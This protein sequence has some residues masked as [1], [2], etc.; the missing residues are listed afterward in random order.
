MSVPDPGIDWDDVVDVIC[1]GAAPGV[2]AY[3]ICCAAADLDVLVI[4]PPE[5]PEAGVADLIAAMTEDLDLPPVESADFYTGAA[6]LAENRT[7]GGRGVAPFVGEHLRQWSAHCLTSGAAVMF[8]QVP[9]VL[10][11][12]HDG[13]G[14]AITAAVL[15]PYRAP[16]DEWLR[17]Q[18]DVHGLV[19]R[20]RFAAMIFDAGRIAGV[21][22]ADGTRIGATGGLAFPIGTGGAEWAAEGHDADL[23]LVG[24]RAGRFAR[25]ELLRR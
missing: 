5:V 7:V 13:D 23:A 3:G 21:E 10:A 11:P 18:A 8:T 24:R 4:E 2:L 12:T 22:L 6:G 14:Q 15:G 1:V 17:E 25:L 19:A 9:D 16:L 20:D